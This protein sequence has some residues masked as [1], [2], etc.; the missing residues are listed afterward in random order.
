MQ[1]DTTTKMALR[2][3]ACTLLAIVSF[4]LL[5]LEY[6][7]WVLLVSTALAAGTLGA[8][9]RDSIVRVVTTILGSALGVGIFFIVQ[10][11][12]L[13]AKI[14]FTF[15]LFMMVYYLPSSYTMAMFWLAV[16]FIFAIG[17]GGMFTTHMVLMRLYDTILG[18][19]CALV[20]A[21]TVFPESTRSSL[22]PQ[23]AEAIRVDKEAFK[24]LKE[25]TCPDRKHL[26]ETM[27][28]IIATFDQVKY[29]RL[30]GNVRGPRAKLLLVCQARV[31]KHLTALAKLPKL[32]E[33]ELIEPIEA[34]FARLDELLQGEKKHPVPLQH[35]REAVENA[36]MEEKVAEKV[37]V[38]ELMDYH[39]TVYRLVQLSHVLDAYQ[40][41]LAGEEKHG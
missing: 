2:V 10:D 18:A 37:D 33:I 11:N 17:L 25:G 7:F 3:S 4:E 23:L 5:P 12:V 9:I 29:E 14:L 21:L 34:A 28:K 19:L 22:L 24:Q 36:V 15:F 27:E 41:A 32:P 8:S 26:Q 20:A 13:V 16:M 35:A 30:V 1:V 38:K 6:I 39:S 40:E 31:S